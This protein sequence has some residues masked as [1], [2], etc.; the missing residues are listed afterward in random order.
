MEEV[1]LNKAEALYRLGDEVNALNALNRVRGERYNGFVSPNETGTALLDAILLG[2]RLE[3]AFEG[4]R[5]FMLKRLGLDLNRTN[6]GEFADGTGTPP[7]LLTYPA[8]G[9]RWQQPI[10]QGAFDS[11]SNLTAEDQNFGY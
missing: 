4:D 3:L 1:W 8:E 6:N 10:P 7:V 2:R 11:N 9:N 5:F